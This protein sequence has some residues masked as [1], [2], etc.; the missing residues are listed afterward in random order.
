MTDGRQKETESEG[1][2][3]GER[4]ERGPEIEAS[5]VLQLH[6]CVPVPS[7]LL[8]PSR[9]HGS[10]WSSAGGDDTGGASWLLNLGAGVL[11]SQGP[12]G[13]RPLSKGG[14]GWHV[15]ARGPRQAG[16]A[17]VWAEGGSS[18]LK[19]CRQNAQ[20]AR[21]RKKNMG[22]GSRAA[23]AAQEGRFLPFAGQRAALAAVRAQGR[24]AVCRHG[25]RSA[26]L[27]AC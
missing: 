24:A 10:T 21:D 3:G 26:P 9:S 14:G 11:V 8:C 7:P 23:H 15:P 22:P 5:A 19:A 1:A 2:G 6:V 18:S 4:E 17:F 25:S 13:T 16:P 27:P 20:R 12:S